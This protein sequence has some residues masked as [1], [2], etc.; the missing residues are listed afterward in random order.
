MKNFTALFLLFFLNSF[1]F[2]TE[3]SVQGVLRDPLGRTVDDG[4]F[5]VTFKI[6]DVASNG[7]FLWSEVHPSVK[8]QHGIFT[9]LLGSI[10]SMEALAFNKKYWIGITV[11]EGVEMSPRTQL[12]TSPYSKSVFGTDNVFPSVGNIGVGTLEPEAAVH[13]INKNNESNILLIKDAS[14]SEQ[15]KI[16]NDGTF[17]FPDGIFGNGELGVGTQDPAAAVH[18]ISNNGEDKLRIDDSNGDPLV[19][20]NSDGNL[21]INNP[22]N[23]AGASVIE[24]PLSINGNLRLY[25]GGV[26]LFDDGT[27]LA[28]AN[29]GGSATGVASPS[30]ATI[31]AGVGE[32]TGTIALNIDEEDK[33][34]VSATT[35]DVNNNLVVDGTATFSSTVSLSSIDV[36]GN[37]SLGGTLDVTGNSSLGGTLDVTGNSALS[38][39]LDVSGATTLKATTVGGAFNVTGA[40]DITGNFIVKTHSSAG[41]HL[42]IDNS[43]E[44]DNEV[45]LRPGTHRYGYLGTNA[46]SWFELHVDNAFILRD[47]SIARDANVTRNSQIGGTLGVSGKVNF[48]NTQ[49]VTSTAGTGALSIGNIVGGHI[50]IDGNEI[51]ARTNQEGSNLN[52]QLEGGG[53]TIFNSTF[54]NTSELSVYGNTTFRTNSATEGGLDIYSG[55]SDHIT[56]APRADGKG[57][58]GWSDKR[59]LQLYVFAAYA[60][61]YNSLSDRRVKENIRFLNSEETL[62]KLLTLRGVQYDAKEGTPLFN[63]NENRSHGDNENILGVIAQEVEKV[64]PGILG[65]E[66]GVY[67]TVQY[68]KFVPIFIEAIKQIKIEKD[69]EIEELKRD[70]DTLLARIVNLENQ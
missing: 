58:I 54:S 2:A 70:Y 37:S 47:L 46:K 31:N 33:L 11:D 63:T 10:T 55:V 9:E 22:L 7:S 60:N 23:E 19:Q 62:A 20:V 13:I 12:T 21:G 50:S 26:V 40:T 49:D 29:F 17:S 35:T 65:S 8:V 30:N 41:G 52:M 56:I 27:Q 44:D 64:F 28:S 67:K 5:K 39:T 69:K 53:L 14:N 36:T 43:V 51:Q 4:N 38:G 45:V 66:S 48:S 34:V 24:H 1:I 25:N 57:I 68:D 18:I 3:F 6:Y 16:A 61:Q 15:I 42:Y 59:W 32:G